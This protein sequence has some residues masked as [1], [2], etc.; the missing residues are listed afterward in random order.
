MLFLSGCA[1]TANAAGET[2]SNMR[3][4]ATQG[5]S[6]TPYAA[7]PVDYAST[8]QVAQTEA[9]LAQTTAREMALQLDAANRQMVDATVTHEANS[10]I[11]AQF[12]QTA[13]VA[14]NNRLSATQTAQPTADARE[15]TQR[16]VTIAQVTLQSGQ[17]TAVKEQPTQMAAMTRADN[18]RQYGWVFMFVQLF[19]M[20]SLGIFLLSFSAFAVRQA[21]TIKPAL[22]AVTQ[23]QNL[24][25]LEHTLP[26][27]VVAP[28]ETVIQM[29]TDNGSGFTHTERMVVP[30][31]PDQL[32]ALANGVINEH[33]SLAFNQWEGA[34]SPFTRDEFTVVRNW[35]L[36]NRLAQS[37]GQG[38]LILSATGE[39]L[40]IEWLNNQKLPETY[41]FMEAVRADD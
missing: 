2:L 4:V 6:K 36:S 35:L 9:V 27:V 33:Q 20:F 17:M 12:T 40:F 30:C 8:A 34:V 11:I 38:K 29:R 18:D 22:V 25:D 28:T 13:Y 16:A 21:Q 5:V 15:A 1:G 3:P 19:A 24:D 10:L 23:I 32:T 31:S 26:P 37:A 7:N 39:T 41:K 14:E